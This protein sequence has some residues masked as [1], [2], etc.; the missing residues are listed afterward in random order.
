M[1][2]NIE[3]MLHPDA[4]YDQPYQKSALDVSQFSRLSFDSGFKTS[5]M[6]NGI[7]IRTTSARIRISSPADGILRIQAVPENKEIPVPVTEELGLVE[8]PS[9]KSGFKCKKSGR[10]IEFGTSKMSGSLDTAT[11]NLE[12]SDANGKQLLK[13][14]DGGLRFSKVPAEY[15]GYR[16]MASFSL[17]DEK[18]FGFGGRIMPPCRNGTSVDIFT[19]KVGIV[20]G[21][22]GGCPVPFYI[23]SKGYGFFLNNPW[24]HVYFDMGKTD[25]RKWFYHAP[26]GDCDIFIFAGPSFR[27]IIGRYTMLTGRPPSPEKWW[28]G[29][30]CSSLTF[31][32]AAE[33]IENAER[34]RKEKYPCEAIVLDGPWRGGP[35]F[36]KIYS[37]GK[38]YISRDFDW[39]AGFGDGAAMIRKL[40][41]MGFKTILHVN[42]RNFA[43]DTAA[44]GVSKGLLRQEGKEV[45]VNVGN[46]KAEKYYESLMM[47]RISEG[48][49][50]WWTDHADRVSGELR[51]GLPSRNLFGVLWNRLVYNIMKKSGRDRRPCLTRGSGIGGQRCGLPWPGDTRVGVDAFKDDIWFCLNAGL[52]GFAY[53]SADLAGFT[54]RTENYSTYPNEKAKLTEALNDENIC[55]RLCQSIILIPIPRIHN[56]WSTVAKFPWRCSAKARKLYRESLDFRYRLSPYIYHWAVHASRT[57]EPILRPMAYHHPDDPRCLLCDDQLFI[58]ENII[59]APIFEARVNSRKVYL[60]KGKWHDWWTGKIYEGPVEI[61]VETPLY[62]L[63][64]LPLFVKDGSAIPMQKKVQ[65]LGAKGKCEIATRKFSNR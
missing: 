4:L 55:R 11:G 8:V 47:P 12:I 32:T 27:E 10:K 41:K 46:R 63:S 48:L 45:V 51:K 23:S 9:R 33:V 54:L 1:N 31:K 39:H 44:E 5:Q 20:S 24:P 7:E 15:S 16:Q 3:I 19:M 30:W 49:E 60:P 13:S 40:K 58:G 42:S 57:G 62:K 61:K 64:G 17:E 22:Y 53:T 35:D 21:D 25:P 37:E 43:P 2:R 34:L 18:I 38:D 29:F 59:A 26:G 14:L 65:L 52:A 50:L 6:P 28:F 56:N 36:V